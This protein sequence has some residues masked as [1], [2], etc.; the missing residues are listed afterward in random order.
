MRCWQSIQLADME[1]TAPSERILQHAE[2]F[3][4]QAA[5]TYQSTNQFNALKGFLLYCKGKLLC[6]KSA[7]LTSEKAHK[8]KAL[9]CCEGALEIHKILYQNRPHI[10]T[11]RTLNGIGNCYMELNQPSDAEIFYRQ[12]LDMKLEMTGGNEKQSEIPTFY[13]QLSQVYEKLGDLKKA[14]K[15]KREARKNYER[16]VS[17]LKKA[18]A[19]NEELDL[20]DTIGTA[21]FNR[22]LANVF[23]AMERYDEAMECAEKSYKVRDKLL[24]RHPETVRILY[25]MG[26][27]N[28]WKKKHLAAL[29]NYEEAFCMEE[30][31]PLEN[32]SIMKDNVCSRFEAMCKKC[33]KEAKLREYKPRIEQLKKVVNY[34]TSMQK[35]I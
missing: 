13:N 9:Q 35:I 14:K 12:A 6:M 29:L 21:T 10:M 2:A 19:L 31:L 16:A 8:Q 20:E 22:N 15:S 5:H 28:E 24:G 18:I 4:N 33:N 27:I 30:S 7:Y 32:H 23:I 11:V 1:G 25:L 3:F 26:V 34:R 17:H